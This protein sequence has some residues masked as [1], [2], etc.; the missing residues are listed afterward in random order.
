MKK[1]FFKLLTEQEYFHTECDPLIFR[2]D[3]DF[4]KHLH[5]EVGSWTAQSSA[6]KVTTTR[7]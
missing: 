4:S 3:G 2:I 5:W 6:D 7:V 1:D